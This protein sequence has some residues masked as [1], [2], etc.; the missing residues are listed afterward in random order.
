MFPGW[1]EGLSGDELVA[2]M[3]YLT[4]KLKENATNMRHAWSDLAEGK[5]VYGNAIAFDTESGRMPGDLSVVDTGS[6]IQL[7][8]WENKGMTTNDMVAWIADAY[9]VSDNYAKM[10]L[11]D[12]K[13]YS[14]DLAQ[15]LNV[16]DYA[17]GIENAYEKLRTVDIQYMQ[18][19]TLLRN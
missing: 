3:Q 6:E 13:N 14:A 8:G 1:R 18:G 16:N 15:E 5:D 7:T 11:A 19:D 9:N 12:F 10:M 17:A 4:G 2:Q